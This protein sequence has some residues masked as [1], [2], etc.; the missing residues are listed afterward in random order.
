M[1]MENKRAVRCQAVIMK[2]DKLLVLCHY[3]RI[4]N[5]EFWLLPGGEKETNETEEECIKRELKEELNIDVEIVSVLFDDNENNNDYERY[6]TFLCVPL[7]NNKIRVGTESNCYKV[8]TK[9]SWI[10]LK[11]ELKWTNH[12]KRAQFFPTLKQI[13]EKVKEL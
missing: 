4:N 8:L 2:N 6:V 1:T 3:N 9:V 7:T 5:E 12:L 11:N 13:K 10:S